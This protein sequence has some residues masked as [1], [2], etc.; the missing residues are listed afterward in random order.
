MIFHTYIPRLLVF[1]GELLCDRTWMF[2]RM[3]VLYY[4]LMIQIP[5][6][7]FLYLRQMQSLLA[8]CQ[9]I[10]HLWSVFEWGTSELLC[11]RYCC[12]SEVTNECK[13][14][15]KKKCIPH[16][17]FCLRTKGTSLWTVNMCLSPVFRGESGG[18]H[19]LISVWG[20]E[21]EL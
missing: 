20:R 18:F 16:A 12:L 17:I 15:R 9:W 13:L 6:S 10:P 5:H 1:Y 3:R 4:K 14:V 19:I 21:S 8:V 2:E 7:S 11:E